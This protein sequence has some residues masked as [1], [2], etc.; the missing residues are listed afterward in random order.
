MLK[1]LTSMRYVSMWRH[2]VW[3]EKEESPVFTYNKRV[4]I[5]GMFGKTR[6]K[7]MV[8][9]RFLIGTHEMD[10]INIAWQIVSHIDVWTC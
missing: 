3:G 7:D 8:K 4:Q 9:N 2:L 6:N 1:P 10:I 5:K